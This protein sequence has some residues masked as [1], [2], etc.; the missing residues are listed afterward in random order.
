M[1]TTSRPASMVLK[2]A[3]PAPSSSGSAQSP[4]ATAATLR[5]L[6]PR[7]AKA[8]LQRN[9]G[10]THA[11]LT[12]AFD[13]IAPPAAAYEP[14]ALAGQRRKWEILRVTFETTLY[15]APPPS[16]PHAHA[17]A[18]GTDAGGAG[19][20]LPEPLR[21]HLMLSPE[22]FIATLHGR[23]LRLFTPAA[24]APS[25]AFVPAQI[26]VTLALASLK[27]GCTAVGRGMV[28]DWLARR[29]HGSGNEGAAED[30]DAAGYAK[31]LEL[32]CLHVLP[33]LEDWVYA[34]DF[35]QYERE[36][37]SD[38]RKY[39]ITSLRDLRAQASQRSSS[40]KRIPQSI[41][42]PELPSLRAPSPSPSTS[43]A[44][45]SS[46]DNT[47]TPRTPTPGDVKGKVSARLTQA[48]TSASSQTISSAATS[49]TVTPTLRAHSKARRAPADARSAADSAR[50]ATP[51][52]LPRPPRAPPLQEPRPP[53]PPSA[54]ALLRE[55]VHGISR[56]RL[57]AYAVLMVVLP[58][59]SLFL[60]VRRRRRVAGGSGGSTADEVRRRL[61]GAAEGKGGAMG[62]VRGAWDELVR[63]VWDTVQMGGRGLV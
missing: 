34:E 55:L 36:L 60:R 62:V 49:R 59:L 27:L 58:L 3:A 5:S 50:T 24:H 13:L 41:T 16:P 63:S 1:T 48:S 6:Y 23:A 51:R 29:P 25:A 19:T 21:A 10:L 17:H 54:L 42:E 4:A 46:S 33:R 57:T 52:P 7:A 26:V 45:S 9:V 11:L 40:S 31:V 20:D 22:P 35:L 12:T 53:R 32:Y 61:R 18:D 39:L 30:V 14:D 38:T 15:A 37:P 44:S 43:S 47:A 56:T 8:F 28:E 2:A